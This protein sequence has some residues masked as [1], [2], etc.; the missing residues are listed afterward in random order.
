MKI[1]NKNLL[2]LKIF[3]LNFLFESYSSFEKKEGPKKNYVF[4]DK[5]LY[6]ENREEFYRK[7]FLSLFKNN[8]FKEIK[9]EKE[10]VKYYLKIFFSEAKINET[11]ISKF[12]NLFFKE[13][14]KNFFSPDEFEN[15][16]GGVKNE[17]NLSDF[18]FES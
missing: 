7:K 15:F 3:F 18:K 17:I 14:A 6:S 8:N 4:Q 1:F 12:K 16:N 9:I 10:S 11:L 2:I 5:S 13:N